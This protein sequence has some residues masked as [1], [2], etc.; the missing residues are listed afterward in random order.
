MGN[1]LIVEVKV[2]FLCGLCGIAC[3]IVYDLLR[4]IRRTLNAG[5]KA[6]FAFDI[7]FWI[8]CASLT[9][10]MIFYANY[11][12]IRW[13][14]AV[15]LIIGAVSYFLS[16][17]RMITEGGTIILNFVIKLIQRILKI[18]LFPFVFLFS[19]AKKT[20]AK[21]YSKIRKKTT[22]KMLTLKRFWFKIKKRMKF[23]VKL[24]RK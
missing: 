1:E 20:L 7:L 3:G 15:G 5:T 4:I 10:G 21:K 18:F 13:Y 22:K 11:G 2:F 24:F 8:I 6:T 23:Y 12:A 17:S 16:V 9:F 14:E 19:I